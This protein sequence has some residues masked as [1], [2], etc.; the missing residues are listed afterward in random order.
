MADK[1]YPP[2]KLPLMARLLRQFFRLLYHPFA[3]TYDWVA[4]T[5]SVGRWKQWVYS[6]LPF[7]HG[8]QVLELGFGPGHLQLRLRAAGFE[9]YGL[10]ESA[11]MARQT[12]QRLSRRS[13][14]PRIAR[15]WAQHLP[16]ADQ[17][18]DSVVATFPTQYII[19]PATL[20]D[21][22]RILKPGGRLVVLFA[23]RIT[24]R[25]LPDR[26]MA[27]VF[28]LTG[29]VPAE[30]QSEETYTSFFTQA[31]FQSRVEVVDLQTSEVMLVVCEKESMNLS[32]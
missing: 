12:Y 22:Q 15:G 8:R 32:I 26:F 13:L 6:T 25:S 30:G 3:W 11:Q 10:D 21:I 9:A 2:V 19:D 7:L 1:I 29:Q 17:S 20:Q 23:A 14:I 27:T 16:F 24:G 5:V 31:G 4:D 18:F 28:Q